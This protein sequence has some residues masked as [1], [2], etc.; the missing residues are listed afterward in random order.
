MELDGSPLRQEDIFALFA[1][2]E[3][4]EPVKMRCWFASK[5]SRYVPRP[6]AFSVFAANVSRSARA[7]PSP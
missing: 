5:F 2:F 6:A 7:L 3:P 4:G 1:M